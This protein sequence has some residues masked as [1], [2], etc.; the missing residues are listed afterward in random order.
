VGVAT[1][2]LVAFDRLRFDDLA[3]DNRPADPDEPPVCA[4]P[5][6]AKMLARPLGVAADD[7]LGNETVF[8]LGTVTLWHHAALR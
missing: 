7:D 8:D 5:L 4:D 3:I 6:A 1:V 2:L